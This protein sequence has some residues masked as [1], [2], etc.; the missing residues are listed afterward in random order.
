MFAKLFFRK[1]K[2]FYDLS[3]CVNFFNITENILQNFFKLLVFVK[4]FL[5]SQIKQNV[6]INKIVFDN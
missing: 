6:F 1:Q 2:H 4:T 3:F 5:S